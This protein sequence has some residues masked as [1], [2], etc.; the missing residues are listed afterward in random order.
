[1][2]CCVRESSKELIVN[3]PSRE[4]HSLESSRGLL[5]V[6]KA[7]FPNFVSSSM[8]KMRDEAGR[9]RRE[10]KGHYPSVKSI[11]RLSVALLS[12]S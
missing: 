1:M 9:E 3:D 12:D 5:L 6:T 4:V 11:S 10:E 8:D 7:R 2:R